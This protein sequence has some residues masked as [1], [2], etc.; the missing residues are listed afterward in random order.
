MNWEEFEKE[1]K[2]LAEKIDWQPNVIIGVVRG[3][4]I[5][6]R[7]L[8]SYLGVKKMYCLSVTNIRNNS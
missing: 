2:I 7:L 6:A 1:V 4:L 5:P 3:G 8:S